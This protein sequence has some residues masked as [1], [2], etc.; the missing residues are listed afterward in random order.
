MRN[1][2]YLQPFLQKMGIEELQDAYAR[3]VEFYLKTYGILE[4]F[5]DN[6]LRNPNLLS[7]SVRKLTSLIDSIGLTEDQNALFWIVKLYYVLALPPG[8]KMRRISMTAFEYTFQDQISAFHPSI[9]YILFL[10]DQFGSDPEKFK[11]IKKS[12]QQNP[13][14]YLHFVSDGQEVPHISQFI[15]LREYMKSDNKGRDKILNAQKSSKPQPFFLANPSLRLNNDLLRK[16]LISPPPLPIWAA[17]KTLPDLEVGKKY[18][19]FNKI[20]LKTEAETTHRTIKT[21]K[22]RRGFALFD[23]KSTSNNFSSQKENTIEQ[24]FNLIEKI[25]NVKTIQ[26]KFWDT[27]LSITRKKLW[28]GL[29]VSS[30]LQPRRSCRLPLPG[31]KLI[32]LK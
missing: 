23:V 3:A 4:K 26:K 12:M 24:Q 1:C 20:L 16:K 17:E 25:E 32:S 18:M 8:W 30:N 5:P 28:D 14:A 15:L 6:F 11:T 9:A 31:S 22:I 19:G 29:Y 13:K 21:S 27:G 10:K 7:T 2:E